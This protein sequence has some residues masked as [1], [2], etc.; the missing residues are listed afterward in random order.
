MTPG[1][2]EGSA[3]V[4]DDANQCTDDGPCQPESGCTHTPRSCDDGDPTTIDT[5]DALRGC[6]RVTLLD[7][8]GLVALLSELQD[9]CITAD[10]TACLL[11][12]PSCRTLV[13]A[14]RQKLSLGKLTLPPGEHRLTLRAEVAFP[15][16]VDLDLIAT[17]LRLIVADATTRQHSLDVAVPGGAPDATR[18]G[19]TRK[20][21]AINAQ[22]TYVDKTAA[23]LT[24]ITKI[25][26]KLKA[27]TG[28]VQIGLSGRG[29]YLM[30]NPENPVTA[31]LLFDPVAESTSLC[32]QLGFS[33]PHSCRFNGSSL[34]CK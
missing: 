28:L 16:P 29:T 4:C 33:S 27:A 13:A 25:K 30:P 34:K 19:W 22:W 6:T 11:E 5:C 24:G 3:S 18:R 8:A 10:P 21:S 32:G 23:P 1:T 7:A 20:V 9:T 15:P 2:C 12:V 26:L 17:G 14:T 31:L